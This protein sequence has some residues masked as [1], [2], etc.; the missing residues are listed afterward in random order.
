VQ[1]VI[2]RFARDPQK[3]L[4]AICAAP[5][6]LKAAKVYQGRLITSHPSVR[7]E[8]DRDYKYTGMLLFIIPY[9]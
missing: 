7:S 2:S 3:L 6:A 4:A 1:A 8:L 5:L 9:E